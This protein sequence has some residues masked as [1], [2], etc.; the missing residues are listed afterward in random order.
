MGPIFPCSRRWWPPRRTSCSADTSHKPPSTRQKCCWRGEGA[1]QPEHSYSDGE[2]TTALNEILA[3]AQSWIASGKRVALA[4]VI[5]VEGSGPRTPGAAM[6]VNQDGEV[7]GSVSG[8]CIEGAVVTEAMTTLETGQCKRLT[9]GIAG[10]DAFAVGLTCG[11]TV[12]IF[13]EQMSASILGTVIDLTSQGRPAALLTMVKGPVIGAKALV[14]PDHILGV[15]GDL[16]LHRRALEEA[17]SMLASSSTG[18]RHF[19]PQGEDSGPE[20]E[21]FVQSF[22]PPPQ[23]YV[24]GAIDFSRATVRI[25]KL[26]GYRVTVC[27]ARETFATRSRFP[28]ADELVAAWPHLFLASAP[29]DQRTVVCV[30]THDLKF[31]VPLLQVALR[32]PA[33]YIGAMGSRRT[34]SLRLQRLAELGVPANELDRILGPIG[35]DIGART[36]EEVAV[37]I[38]AE[39]IALRYG[40]PAFFLSQRS[41]PVHAQTSAHQAGAR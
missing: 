24:F 38:A 27:D 16:P 17:R 14:T 23:M 32:T 19:C 18:V 41:G 15:L 36:P 12:Q 30:L 7:V 2:R 6:A 1:D 28:E 29:V 8:G 33:G 34:H 35:L 39:I 37:A 9:Y 20:V 21:I 10:D 22:A 25:G 5:E 40:R 31:D 26:L 4:T 3:Q 11:G 13:V